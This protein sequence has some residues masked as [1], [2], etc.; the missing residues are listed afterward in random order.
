ME[1]RRKYARRKAVDNAFAVSGGIPCSLVDVSE[2]GL[3]LKYTGDEP[4]PEQMTVDLMYL[5]REL[6]LNGIWCRKVSDE[7]VLRKTVFSYLT[8]R[9]IGL[10]FIAPVEEMW[11]VLEEFVGPEN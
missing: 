7:K 10:E 9:R 11:E 4:L 5:S 1:E 2:G 3:G 6:V 8:E